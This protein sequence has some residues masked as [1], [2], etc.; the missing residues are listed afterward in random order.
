MTSLSA[1]HLAAEGVKTLVGTA[2]AA[3]ASPNTLS[4]DAVVIKERPQ[5]ESGDAAEGVFLVPVAQTNDPVTNIRDDVGHGVGVVIYRP[6]NQATE[7]DDKL[8][9][10][11]DTAT[12]AVRRK[13]ISSANVHLTEIEPRSVIDA[14]AFGNN[15]SVASFVAR[16]IVRT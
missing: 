10:W 4:A 13:R 7:A 2:L 6:S 8:H 16:C 12:A 5:K 14:Q 15:H 11:M 9:L 3:L 1:W